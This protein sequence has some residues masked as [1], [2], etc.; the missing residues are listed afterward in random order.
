M[1]IAGQN[2]GCVTPGEILLDRCWG[3]DLEDSSSSNKRAGGGGISRDS[4]GGLGDFG[5]EV[6]GFE[7]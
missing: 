4:M 6:D 3:A 7:F 2:S 5:A 1:L